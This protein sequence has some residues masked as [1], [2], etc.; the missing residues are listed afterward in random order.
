[1]SEVIQ[2]I[3]IEPVVEQV[4][5]TQFMAMASGQCIGRVGVR[6]KGLEVAQMR[7]LYVEPAHRGQGLGK[8]LVGACLDLAVK[9]GCKSLNLTIAAN[10]KPVRPFYERMG[11]I[12]CM[13]YLD[14]EVAMVV[15]LQASN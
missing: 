9:D 12:V 10:N 13:E 11:F 2:I 6:T 5:E 7:Q 14:G 15:P 3:T 1:M 4:H 8:R